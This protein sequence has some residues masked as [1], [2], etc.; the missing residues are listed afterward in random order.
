MYKKGY[1]LIE[2]IVGLAIFGLISV[3]SYNLLKISYKNSDKVELKLLMTY[4]CQEVIEELKS[5][6][7]ENNDIFNSLIAEG[8]YLF[9]NDKIGE[10]YECELKLIKQEGN[11]IF[12]SCTIK[13]SILND[14]E[15]TLDC[16][17][18]FK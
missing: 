17:R 6:T 16:S 11:L 9:K 8:K 18:F 3:T 10:G 12:Y 5:D 2:I 1:M 14:S 15:V 7:P 4:L 13:N